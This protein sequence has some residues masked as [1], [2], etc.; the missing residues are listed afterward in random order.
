L[1]LYLKIFTRPSLRTTS[2]G[3]SV[4]VVL[5]EIGFQKIT[6]PKR[7]TSKSPCQ[8]R[9]I[10]FGLSFFDEEDDGSDFLLENVGEIVVEVVGDDCAG[11]IDGCAIVDDGCIEN[12]DCVRI[13]GCTEN[14]DCGRGGSTFLTIADQDTDLDPDLKKSGLVDLDQIQIENWFSGPRSGS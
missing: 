2:K 6:F 1:F 5:V 3:L 10:F 13:G 12:D 11:S 4:V 7:S 14:D 9:T 8:V